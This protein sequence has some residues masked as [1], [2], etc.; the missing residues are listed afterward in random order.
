[1]FCPHSTSLLGQES[2]MTSLERRQVVLEDVELESQVTQCQ[3]TSS[4][5]TLSYACWTMTPK[6]ASRR[7]MLCST[8]SS[9]K[10]QMRAQTLPTV[11]PLVQPWSSRVLQVHLVCGLIFLISFE[12]VDSQAFFYIYILSSL[13]ISILF[14]MFFFL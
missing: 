9:R 10:Q 7:T 1:M 5:K 12:G 13:S 11:P 2:Y 4:S 14:F 6:R 8:T 3:I